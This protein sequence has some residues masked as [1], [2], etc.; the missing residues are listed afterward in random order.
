MSR[1]ADPA[2]AQRGHHGNDYIKQ[3]TAADEKHHGHT[4]EEDPKDGVRD[5]S[6]DS[7]DFLIP[8][9]MVGIDSMQQKPENHENLEGIV[10]QFTL[11]GW[12][13]SFPGMICQAQDGELQESK[14]TKEAGQVNRSWYCIG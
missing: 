11:V 3:G 13:K 10:H 9:V 5:S 6:S 7:G 4:G 1:T 12:Q 2:E 14:G 8:R